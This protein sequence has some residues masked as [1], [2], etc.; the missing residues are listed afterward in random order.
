M[1][2]ICRA[3][4]FEFLD[5]TLEASNRGLIDGAALNERLE[6]FRSLIDGEAW[7]SQRA[8]PLGNREQWYS[9][10]PSAEGR[11]GSLERGRPREPPPFLYWTCSHIR[12]MSEWVCHKGDADPFP[13][14]PHGHHVKRRPRKLD[15]YRGWI[16]DNGVSAGRLRRDHI[17]NLW[18]DGS[19]RSFAREA[20]QH[21][22]R[23]NP[24]Y[25]FPV[26]DPL[27]LP[28]RR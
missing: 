26:R 13:S 11:G 8:L 19:F 23:A 4:A 24:K 5:L 17:V 25:Q 3:G 18:N 15:V 20:L 12:G 10:E 2:L 1:N 16:F 27:R 22:I 6:S 14:V 28:R 21:F 9:A 7:P